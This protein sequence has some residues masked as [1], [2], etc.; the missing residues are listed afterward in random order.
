MISK[1]NL[2]LLGSITLIGFPLIGLLIQFLFT[3]INF[4]SLLKFNS[5][6]WVYVPAGILFGI[7]TAMIAERISEIKFISKSTLDFSEFFKNLNLSL[8]DISFLAFAAGFGEEILFRGAI[9]ELLG[10]WL[11]S[12]LFIAIHGY[13]NIK[14]IGMFIF[15]IYLILFSAFLGYLYEN[16]SLWCAIS[17][18]FS[19]DFVLLYSLRKSFK[20]SI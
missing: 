5:N 7:S 1:N 14:K 16:Y 15:G 11:T 8:F 2:Y 13:L 3:E 19:Y 6:D 10:V 9:Q 18:H 20:T 12:I 4:I 17:A